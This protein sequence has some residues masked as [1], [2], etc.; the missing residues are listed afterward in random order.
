VSAVL[1]VTFWRLTPVQI[2]PPDFQNKAIRRE[3][4]RFEL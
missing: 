2:E 3:C 4:A 1:H